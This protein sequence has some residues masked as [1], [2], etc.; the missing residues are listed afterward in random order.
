MADHKVFDEASLIQ[1]SGRVGRT[2]KYPEGE[3]L[4]LC[5]KQ[6][7]Q[8]DECIRKSQKANANKMFV[9]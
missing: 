9:V 3:C 4:F 2:F 8:V 5:K 1:M 7:E 6:S